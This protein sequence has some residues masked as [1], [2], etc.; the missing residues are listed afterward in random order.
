MNQILFVTFARIYHNIFYEIKIEFCKNI[1]DLSYFYIE[2]G[3]F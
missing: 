2:T 3:F 1:F